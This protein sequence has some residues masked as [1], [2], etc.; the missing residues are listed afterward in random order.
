MAYSTEFNAHSVVV[1]Q[2]IV[3][4]EFCRP[5]GPI[6]KGREERKNG[7]EEK[8]RK[9]KGGVHKDRRNVHKAHTYFLAK[10]LRGCR[11]NVQ[12]ASMKSRTHVGETSILS[13]KCRRQNIRTHFSVVVANKTE[14]NYF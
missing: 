3:V 14:A 12:N 6:S 4:L 10:H 2:L 13:A 9:G 11:R 1:I 5:W 7:M 8:G